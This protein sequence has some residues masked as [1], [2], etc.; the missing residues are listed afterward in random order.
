MN[1]MKQTFLLFLLLSITLTAFAQD[2]T[3]IYKNTVNSTVTIETEDGLGSGFF[4]GENI[5][6]TNYHVIKGDTVAYCYTN[7][8]GI[9][10]KIEG[11]V[12]VDTTVDLILLKVSGLKRT[13]IRLSPTPVEIG[14]KI[15]VIGSPKGL[16]ATISDGIVSAL[17]DFDGYKLIQITAAT[18]PGSSG[19]P[20]LNSKGEL[21]G[22]S[23]A[24][25]KEGQNLNFA[26][27]KSNLK[28]LMN[29]KKIS[30][31]SLAT[32]IQENNKVIVTAPF[33][34]DN[35]Q[36]VNKGTS[37]IIGTQ[38]WATVNLNVTTFRNGDP[39]PEVESTD[40]WLLSSDQYNGKPA[41]CYYKGDLANASE[42]GKLYNWYAVH[43]SRGLAPPG[44]H[45]PSEEEWDILVKYLGGS[46][47]AGRKMKSAF[48]WENNGNG[49]NS[50]CFSAFPRG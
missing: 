6:A 20:V 32:L 39:I 46:W 13:P 47:E 3:L 27:P 24:S 4:V 14:Q 34:P 36:I 12:A 45:I 15:Y 5:I 41:W 26:I 11:Y 38:E 25:L 1:I 10:Y 7:N 43:D 8:S 18:S 28:V 17:R 23:V 31:L 42:S 19:G 35:I 33:K 9:K 44:W 50:C 48:G 29:N 22:V 2:A 21:I 30:A 40:D 37:V 16:P 49:D